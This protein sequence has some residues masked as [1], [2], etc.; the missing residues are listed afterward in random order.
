M[1][2]T[3]SKPDSWNSDLNDGLGIFLFTAISNQLWVLYSHFEDPGSFT[4][5][6]GIAL[7]R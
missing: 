2:V 4:C 3:G 1:K 6:E 5:Y 7:Q